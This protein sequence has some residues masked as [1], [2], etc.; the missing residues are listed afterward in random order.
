MSPG[1]TSSQPTD[2][3]SLISLTL[4]SIIYSRNAKSWKPSCSKALPWLSTPHWL[5]LPQPLCYWYLA[6]KSKSHE[7]LPLSE[8]QKRAVSGHP[9][10]IFFTKIKI[11]RVWIGHHVC[12]ESFSMVTRFWS[13]S[14]LTRR[15]LLLFLFP[16]STEAL[17]HWGLKV[18]SGGRTISNPWVMEL[19]PQ[20]RSSHPFVAAH[21]CYCQFLPSSSPSPGYNLPSGRTSSGEKKLFPHE[22][23]MRL[24]HA[25][26]DEF[27]KW[28]ST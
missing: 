28:L 5:Q 19:T 11:V 16:L 1:S 7:F 26:T 3:L 10:P 6:L 27:L 25:F 8:L 17:W 21:K 14:V 22:V 23:W 18:T 20:S 15:F 2:S 4:V 13:R 24:W 12:R 9:Q